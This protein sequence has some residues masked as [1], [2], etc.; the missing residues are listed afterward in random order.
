MLR[1]SARKTFVYQFFLIAKRE[2]PPSSR[3][4]RH[5]GGNAGWQPRLWRPAS[6]QK[7]GLAAVKRA[8]AE[9]ARAALA[10]RYEKAMRA[11]ADVQAAAQ[12]EGPETMQ[13][14]CCPPLRAD[15]R[16]AKLDGAPR[17]MRWGLDKTGSLSEV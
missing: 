12:A 5:W 14:A 4:G 8:E 11:L 9:A 2:P 6:N 13:R 16:Q 15:R 10:E 7:P 17:A 1:W 3:K